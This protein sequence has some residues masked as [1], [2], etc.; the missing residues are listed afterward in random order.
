MQLTQH[1]VLRVYQPAHPKASYFMRRDDFHELLKAPC[2][3][4]SH[5]LQFS[6]HQPREFRQIPTADS[7]S[8]DSRR[9]PRVL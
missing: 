6:H 3:G 2:A 5:S 4:P 1:T 7:T 8:S 9:R